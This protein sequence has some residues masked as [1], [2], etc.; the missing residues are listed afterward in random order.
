MSSIIASFWERESEVHFENITTELNIDHKHE[1]FSS[2]DFLI[3]PSVI[4]SLSDYGPSIS[5]G[6]I[7]QDGMDDFFIGSDICDEGCEKSRWRIVGW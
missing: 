4:H 6:D 2:Y 7:N 5:V 3:T 1:N